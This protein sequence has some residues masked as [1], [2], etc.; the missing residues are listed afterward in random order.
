MELKQTRTIN[1]P[2]E[3]VWQ[4]LND[5]ETLKACIPGCESFEPDGENAYKA[6]VAARV[7]PVSARFNA[8]DMRVTKL[9][10]AAQC[11]RSSSTR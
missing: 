3:R 6:T 1:A 7:G 5:P 2:R 9:S 11:H 4:A 10:P 8:S